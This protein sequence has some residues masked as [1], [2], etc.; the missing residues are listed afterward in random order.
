MTAAKAK[1]AAKSKRRH[2][3][4]KSRRRQGDIASQP[5]IPA[6][7]A[8]KEERAFVVEAARSLG[9][10]AS[11]FIATASLRRAEEVTG[12]PRPGAPKVGPSLVV[13]PTA[14]I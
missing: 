6:R 14:V 3:Y 8:S 11:E 10:S 7:F 2:S 13:P 4:N 9:E 5:P 1:T 12:Q